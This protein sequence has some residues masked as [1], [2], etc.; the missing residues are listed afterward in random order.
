M[1]Y[2]FVMPGGCDARDAVALAVAAEQAGWDGFFTWE[3]VWGTDAWVSL[4]AAAMRT[5]RIRLGT[6][7]TPLPRRQPWEVASQAATLDNLSGGRVVLSVGLGAT[8][9]RWWLFEDDPGVRVR[10]ERLDEGLA[11]LTGL[12][13][14]E[15]FDYRGR[16]VPARP[17]DRMVPDPP[18]QQPR[19]PVWVVGAWPRRKSMRRAA[20][21]DGWLPNYLPPD[22]THQDLTPAVM[23]E[24]VDWIG[25]YRA[26]HGIP[27]EYQVVT[28]NT[29]PADD[30]AAAAATVRPWR[31]AGATWYLEA[32]WS[33]SPEQ[34][35]AA[36]IRRLEAGPPRAE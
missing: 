33:V 6:M 35:R 19:V 25:R 12:W 21:Y 16:H 18:A 7:L 5:D 15:P 32:N 3:G 29:T 8:D 17:A 10:A 23:R 22:G 13:S 24:A 11:M 9:A 2:G 34:A 31:D 14:G 26:E 30:P 27:G 1:R 28:E 20:R 4:T 36:S